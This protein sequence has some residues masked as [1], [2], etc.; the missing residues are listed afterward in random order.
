VEI[1]DQVVKSKG[2]DAKVMEQF[3]DQNYA[4]LS[5]LQA[6][7]VYATQKKVQAAFST[8]DRE[9]HGLMSQGA[10]LWAEQQ[11]YG[12]RMMLIFIRNR[13]WAMTTGEKLGKN[14]RILVFQ[15]RELQGMAPAGAPHRTLT[16]TT[17]ATRGR[18]MLKRRPSS[19]KKQP[20]PEPEPT[21]KLRRLGMFEVPQATSSQEAA[22]TRKFTPMEVAKGLFLPLAP[23]LLGAPYW[24]AHRNAIVRLLD[25]VLEEA[26]VTYQGAAGFLVGV[27]PDG[28][29]ESEV[30]NLAL[31]KPEP[32]R[33]PKP[34]GKGKAKGK[35]KAKAQSSACASTLI[36]VSDEGEKDNENSRESEEEEGG[37]E[38]D[39]ESSPSYTPVDDRGQDV[40]LPVGEPSSKKAAQVKAK[41][42][43]AAKAKAKVA[44]KAK[45]KVAAKAKAK[46]K[47]K[48]KAK[49]K[50]KAK[51]RVCQGLDWKFSDYR[52][53]YATKGDRVR[54][55]MQGIIMND[56]NFTWRF[57]C[58][59][60]QK[61]TPHHQKIME[62]LFQEVWRYTDEDGDLTKQQIREMCEERLQEALNH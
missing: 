36:D 47:P 19:P 1:F 20:A 57:I 33:K 61:Q 23:K 21:P 41:A 27:F 50:A 35:A 14:L 9:T 40:E 44:A 24:D 51:G 13:A 8:W 4:L 31:E 10:A 6:L 17:L 34:K 5:D 43:V 18:A 49:A 12:L 45:G 7:D 15:F 58:E 22:S 48:A 28:E 37:T 39:V 3:I 29:W 30:P 55:Y 46:G 25:G 59:I 26:Q 54:T 42:K 62:Q 32:K 11:A 2:K 53:G 38:E 52:L 16:T 60:T 56:D